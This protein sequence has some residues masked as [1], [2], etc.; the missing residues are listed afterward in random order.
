MYLHSVLG[1]GTIGLSRVP[2][3]KD[4]N[5]GPEPYSGTVVAPLR[6]VAVVLV[7]TCM[8]HLVREEGRGGGACSEWGGA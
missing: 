3:A 1:S 4:L 7:S 6:V 5:E 8:C 2:W